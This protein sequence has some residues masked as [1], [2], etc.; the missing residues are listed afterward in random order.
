MR[1]I[2]HRGLARNASRVLRAVAA[3]KRYRIT[4]AG[5]PVADLV[6]LRAPRRTFVAREVVVRILE[7]AP[8][9]PRFVEDV[10]TAV[11]GTVD[12]L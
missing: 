9:D 12:D 2:A 1:T 3:G 6:P 11:G 8:L 4:V 5:R 7:R 10:N